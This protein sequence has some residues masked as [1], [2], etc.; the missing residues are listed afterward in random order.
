MNMAIGKIKRMMIVEVAVMLSFLALIFISLQL[1]SVIW[2]P[3][4]ILSIMEIFVIIFLVL[5]S[6]LEIGFP[7]MVYI[8]RVILPMV[9][10]SVLSSFLS[11]LFVGFVLPTSI[12]TL[13]LEVIVVLFLEIGL[14]YVFTNSRERFLIRALICKFKK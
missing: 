5:N 12:F 14:C 3:F 1:L 4:A 8:Q 2:L 13:I 10:L 9:G 11:F 6:V 7:Y